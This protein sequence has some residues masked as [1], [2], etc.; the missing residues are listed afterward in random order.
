MHWQRELRSNWQTLFV[1]LTGTDIKGNPVAGM[2]PS[3]WWEQIVQLTKT[4]KKPFGIKGSPRLLSKNAC[5]CLAAACISQC[6]CPHCTTFLENLD[7]RNLAV[8]CGWRSSGGDECEECGGGCNDPQGAWLTMGKGL[9]E[10]TKKILCPPV[11][12]P[13]IFVNSV[14]PLTGFEIPGSSTPLK[15]VPRK[16]WLG[17][18][19]RCGWDN[20]FAK[21][22][23]L[24][25]SL[26]EDNDIERKVFVRACPV[27]ATLDLKTT[28]HEFRKMERG[29]SEDGSL[30]TQPEWTPVTVNR[31]T[32]YYRLYCFMQDFLP[33]Y[34]KVRWH[35]TFDEVFT[36]QYRRLAFKG[37]SGH[38]QPVKSME[39]LS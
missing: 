20:R 8:Q 37:M 7:H 23:L 24:P 30:Y 22:P 12:I 3:T 13:G 28:Y 27:E 16:C 17:Q 36:Q 1:L 9:I 26:K 32:F 6:S 34:Y 18:C 25:L 29:T 33:H 4:E 2:A 10:F 14:D 19:D 5:R 38:P 21:F 31:R 39:G 15:L 35:E 11:K